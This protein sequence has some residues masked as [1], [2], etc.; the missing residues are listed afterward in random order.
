MFNAKMGLGIA[1]FGVAGGY[2]A[3]RTLKSRFGRTNETMLA[4]LNQEQENS[5]LAS[6]TNKT[7][8]NR[9]QQ[10]YKPASVTI[11]AK[12][13]RETVDV[14]VAAVKTV[15]LSGAIALTFTAKA[16]ATITAPKT[17]R[18]DSTILN[19]RWLISRNDDLVYMLGSVG[20][21]L[22][23]AYAT[24]VL[25]I[26]PATLFWLWALVLDGPH[27]WGTATRT[28]FDKQEWNSRRRLLVGSLA[29]FGIGAG[30]ASVNLSLFRSFAYTW[31]YY[32]LVKQHYGF[33]VLYK[34]KNNDLNE[35]DNKLDKAMVWVGFSYPFITAMFKADA[36]DIYKTAQKLVPAAL[37]P[38]IQRL[39]LGAFVAALG[40]YV[41]RQFYKLRNNL[42]FNTPKHLLLTAS[43]GLHIMVMSLPYGQIVDGFL[44]IVATLTA[45]HNVQY[46]RLMWFHNRNKYGKESIAATLKTHGL[47]A[48]F[49]RNFWFYLATGW[50][51]T[52][53]YRPVLFRKARRGRYAAPLE[54]FFWGF[55]FLHYYLDSKIWHVRRDANLNQALKMGAQAKP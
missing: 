16:W 45:Y 2:L 25:K 21:S 18:A 55:A 40:A 49:G 8:N 50:L 44:L 46:Q 20:V 6:H 10:D 32:H 14:A 19:P 35:L 38:L 17:S 42:V 47:A 48:Y 26:K 9:G 43:I 1:A 7:I 37:H 34:K 11:V 53:V 30:L 31:A 36:P 13:V 33:M 27:I 5:L 4:L 15:A 12:M 54:G 28:Y 41:A 51:F 23:L 24:F 29:W 22:A 52:L 3:Y 39:A